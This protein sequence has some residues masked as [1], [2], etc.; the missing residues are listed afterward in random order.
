M[1]QVVVFTGPA[2]F[3][4]VSVVRA[5]LTAAAVLAG[6]TIRDRIDSTVQLLVASR[7]DTVKAKKAEAMGIAVI[8]YQLF[9][10]WLQQAGCPI[11][12]SGSRPD[13]YVDDTFDLDEHVPDFTKDK[14]GD[15]L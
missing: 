9:G 11:L 3:N 14:Y 1:T 2:K 10:V 7:T 15:L 8:D 4:G 12:K 5:D 6:Y 13:Y